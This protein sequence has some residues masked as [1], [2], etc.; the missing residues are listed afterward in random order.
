MGIESVAGRVAVVTGSSKGIGKAVARALAAAGAAVVINGRS[1]EELATT[2]K[3]LRGAGHE[4]TGVALNVTKDDGP[5]RLV[6]AAAD[7]YGPVS[8]VVNMVA[9]NPYMGSVLEVPREVF[10]KV[11]V[12]N[13]WTAV[14][15]VQAAVRHGLTDQRGAVVNIST[16]G[17]HQYQPQLAAYCASKAALDVI[18]IHQANELGP[19]GVRVNTVAPG[20]IQT[21]M[22]RV[23]WEGEAG[24]FESSVLPMRRLGRPEDVA[25]A[26]TFLLSDDAQWITGCTVSVDGGR[27]VT[28]LTPGSL[29]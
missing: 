23:L 4:V 27:L 2:E 13:T 19:H 6:A 11:M 1:E 17:A 8:Y 28:S 24:Q 16:I 18:T 3:E 26:V 20:L 21:E 22:A 25:A 14:A 15:V 12:A 29:P 10:S 5:E 9:I 7:R